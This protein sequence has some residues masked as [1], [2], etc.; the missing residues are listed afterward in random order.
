MPMSST[1]AIEILT[2][3]GV[4]S[5]PQVDQNLLD[6]VKLGIE[7][8]KRHQATQQ[9]NFSGYGKLLSGETKDE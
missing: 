8:L 5:E 9:Y 2:D 3:W 7:A 4:I 1:K 6:A